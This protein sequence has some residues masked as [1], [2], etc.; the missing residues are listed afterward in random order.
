MTPATAPDE[1]SDVKR[2]LL[3]RLRRADAGDGK[4]RQALVKVL[5]GVYHVL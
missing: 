3:E 4:Q 1:L 5:V 2:R